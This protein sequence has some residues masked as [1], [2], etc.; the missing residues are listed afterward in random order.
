MKGLQASTTHAAIINFSASS[1]VA[2]CNGASGTLGW[3]MLWCRGCSDYLTTAAPNNV[4]IGT[5][6][7]TPQIIARRYTMALWQ[8]P[9]L[10][11]CVFLR[12]GNMALVL[13]HGNFKPRMIWTG[14]GIQQYATMERPHP[15]FDPNGRMTHVAVDINVQHVVSA[16]E[17]K[18]CSE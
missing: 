15:F 12:W 7:T 9:G 18:G 14:V 16:S 10:R 13:R 11:S 3:A 8:Q 1:L 17:S 2:H 6:F 4:G 5:C